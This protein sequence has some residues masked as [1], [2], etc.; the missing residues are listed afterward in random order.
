MRPPL[1]T[2]ALAALLFAWGC[3][4]PCLEDLDAACAPLYEPLWSNVYARTLEP[5]CGTGGSTCHSAEGA[6][7]GFAVGDEQSTWEHLLG[8]DGGSAP[9][10]AGDPECSP[11]VRLLRSTDSSEQMPPG[12]PLS[13]AEICAVQRWIADGATQ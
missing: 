5:T 12:D 8:R 11:I 2:A 10:V 3:N 6:Q 13:E 7:G 1:T 4:A 9:V